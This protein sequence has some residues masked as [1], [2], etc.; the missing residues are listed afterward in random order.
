M[1][2]FVTAPFSSEALNELKNILNDEVVYESWLNT[3]KVYFDAEE[4]VE[5]IKKIGAEVYICEGDNVK[6]DVIENLNLKIIGS[7]RGDP[8]NIDIE[9]ATSKQIPVLF[10]PNRNTTAVAELTITLMLALSRKLHKVIKIIN[11]DKFQVEEFSDYTKYYKMFKGHELNG[12]DIGIIG[13]GRIGF[14]VAKR[15][16][17]FEVNFLIY[18]PYVSQQKLKYIDGKQV[19]VDTLMRES[20][21]VSIHC[22]PTDETDGLVG[23]KQFE[24]MKPTAFFINLGRASVTDEY[25]LFDILKE[26]KIAGAALDVF[27]MEPVDQDN[28]FLELENVIV[29]PHLGGDTYETN[30]KHG[31]MM[32]NGIKSILNHKIPDNIMNPEVLPGF[33]PEHEKPIQSGEEIPITLSYFRKESKEII[34]ICNRMLDDGLIIGTAG[35]VSMRVNLPN[36]ADAFLLTPSTV[37]YEN[38]TQEDLVLVDH[39]IKVIAGTRNPTSE[40]HLHVNVMLA[41]DD[42][43]AVIHSHAEYS[44]IL[45]IARMPLGPIV[46]EIIP[47]IGG[48]EIAEYGMAGSE[49]IA[50]KVV[51]ALG[52]NYAVFVANH[53]NVCCGSNMKHA[54]TVLQQVEH[55]AKI[56]YRASLLGTMYAL[57]EEAEADEKEMFEIMRELGNID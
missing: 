40:K 55:A 18:D 6:K 28:E 54:F 26:G 24:L 2:A 53:G 52:N 48:C 32:V 7:T 31:M 19:D 37:R 27:N 57:P 45:S 21:I 38:M 42:I 3:N 43:N 4:L 44:T 30:H 9:T 16:K 47:F 14:E 50:N 22:A 25:A 11:S 56:Q 17:P 35:N 13:L 12:K 46:D 8:N 5:R 36:G 41:R 49:D 29:T 20:D 34:D 23:K 15:L 51:H 1:K 39:N 33:V 10:A